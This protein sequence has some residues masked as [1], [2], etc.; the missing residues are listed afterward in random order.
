MEKWECD[1]DRERK[2]N[3]NIDE[4]IK[5]QRIFSF[6]PLNPRDAFFGGRTENIVK[7]YEANEKKIKYVDVCSLYPYICKY[8]KFPVGHPKIFVDEKCRALVG[9]ENNISNTNDIIKCKIVAPK[10]LYHP[11]LPV[12]MHGRLLFVLCRTCCENSL[13]TF[14]TH[15]SIND[16][17][18]EG[19]WILE[20]LKK[21][22]EKGY[23]ILK[24]YEIW[25]NKITQYNPITNEGL[26]VNYI[27]TF[28]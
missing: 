27:N 10:N 1:F 17:A 9:R 12:K 7:L 8:G 15:T 21:A 14:C 26:F 22:A 6:Q 2:E 5:T 11:V 13:K 23:E 28:F 3:S 4:F 18:F 19:M 24:I 20:E 16:R 25:Q